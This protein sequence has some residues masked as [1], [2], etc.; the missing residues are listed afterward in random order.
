MKIFHIEHQGTFLQDNTSTPLD[1]NVAQAA[2]DLSS[3]VESGIDKNIV[4]AA[5]NFEAAKKVSALNYTYCLSANQMENPM[6]ALPSAYIEGYLRARADLQRNMPRLEADIPAAQILTVA[7]QLN[8]TNTTEEAKAT[9]E[10]LGIDFEEVR[11]DDKEMRNVCAVAEFPDNKQSFKIFTDPK[12]L[13]KW[14]STL[15]TDRLSLHLYST[16][17]LTLQKSLIDITNAQDKASFL[18]SMSGVEKIMSVKDA[19]KLEKVQTGLTAEQA[20]GIAGT[21]NANLRVEDAG[22][23]RAKA[24]E[25][26]KERFSRVQGKIDPDKL[27]YTK[28]IR[29]GLTPASFSDKDIKTLLSGQ[30]SEIKKIYFADESGKIFAGKAKLKVSV[31]GSVNVYGARKELQVSKNMKEGLGTPEQIEAFKQM[32]RTSPINITINGQTKRVLPYIDRD[33]NVCF[34]KDLSKMS[35]PEALASKLGKDNTRE[36]L[37]GKAAKIDNYTDQQGNTYSA[38]V[39]L[40]PSVK[41]GFSISK[42]KPELP[43]LDINKFQQ[44]MVKKPQ[45]KL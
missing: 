11:L 40:N 16:D 38:Y 32:G 13:E 27:D 3:A 30:I 6:M 44:N 26:M 2:A 14:I 37:S 25:S 43:K 28:L 33:L 41:E 45:I 20:V 19:E 21:D 7:E 4:A 10:K 17:S 22:D 31:D 39:Y 24:I 15:D 36:L 29:Y 18:D 9:L 8:E 12:E 5:K 42:E 23:L 1:S 34:Y 35:I